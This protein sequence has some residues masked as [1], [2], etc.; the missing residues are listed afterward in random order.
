MAGSPDP[1]LHCHEILPERFIRVRREELG[2][3]GTVNE[4]VISASETN[5]LL[6]FGGKVTGGRRGA[7][8]G[9]CSKSVPEI[10]FHSQIRRM[11]AGW[12]YQG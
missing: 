2:K 4:S 8:F 9:T 1:F 12:P 7:T 6:R 10:I 3:I 5:L 11:I